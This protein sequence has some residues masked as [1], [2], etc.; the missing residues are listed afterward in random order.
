M[1]N[2]INK[3]FAET[4]SPKTSDTWKSYNAEKRVQI[5]QREIDNSSKYKNFRVFK[6]NK[7][8]EVVLETTSILG[9]SERSEILLDLENL[10]KDKIDLGIT[11]W[12]QLLED[13]SKLRKLRGI[14][15]K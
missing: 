8:G 3:K 10:L 7:N 1:I 11:V 13:K 4:E 5:V 2:Y 15:F 6:T 14:K 9:A 12:L